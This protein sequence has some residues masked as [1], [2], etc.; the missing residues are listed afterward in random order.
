M[1]TLHQAVER[2]LAELGFR[3]EHRRFSA[4]F[5]HRSRPRRRSPPRPDMGDLLSQYAQFVVGTVAVREVLVF[6]SQLERSGPIYTV[7]GRAPLGG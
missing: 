7:L 2:A 5:D 4:P 1:V 6:S 3:P